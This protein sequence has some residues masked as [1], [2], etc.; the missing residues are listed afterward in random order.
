MLVHQESNSQIRIEDRSERT[1][2]L[3]DCVTEPRRV[4]ERGKTQHVERCDQGGE[5]IIGS[6]DIDNLSNSRLWIDPGFVCRGRGRRAICGARHIA[7]DGDSQRVEGVGEV[8]MHRDIEG[9]VLQLRGIR[10]QDCFAEA[11]FEI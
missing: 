1:I 6:T 2:A 9:D 4:A 11:I 5:F 3:V 7:V 10:L 8:E